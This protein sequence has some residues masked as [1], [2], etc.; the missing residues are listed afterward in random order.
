M[1]LNSSLIIK[2]TLICTFFI[3]L[4]AGADKQPVPEA[5]VDKATVTTPEIQKDTTP[6]K[7][8]EAEP[9]KPERNG[10]ATLY[11]N[12]SYDT[13]DF[14]MDISTG[15]GVVLGN[16]AIADAGV[17]EGRVGVSG[18]LPGNGWSIGFNTTAEI[19]FIKND[20]V[21]TLIPGLMFSA[22]FG[23]RERWIV[24]IMPYP[25]PETEYQ[26]AASIHW[27][28]DLGGYLKVFVS[29]Q[30]AVIP[31]LGLNYNAYSAD[32]THNVKSDKNI[33]DE[34]ITLTGGVGL[35]QYF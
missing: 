27:S 30:F 26:E 34:R 23:Y 29:K 9:K 28:F 31:Y 17:L 1:S 19:N 13:E 5:T 15:Y 20:G 6:V 24:W 33:R 16:S 14:S 2:F 10:F 25:P 8:L 21:N 18:G 22:N 35:R 4:Y 3:G 32:F 12:S 11:L 7:V